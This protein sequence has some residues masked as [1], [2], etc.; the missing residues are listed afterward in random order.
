LQ[1][2]LFYGE[3]GKIGNDNVAFESAPK[4]GT[5]AVLVNAILGDNSEEGPSSSVM[6]VVGIRGAGRDIMANHYELTLFARSK[7]KEVAEERATGSAIAPLKEG[8]LQRVPF[9]VHQTGCFP[10]TL[11]AELG[12]PGRKPA[13]LVERV[14]PFRCEE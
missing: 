9:V 12:L 13:S 7:G 14:I 3:S 2:F 1:A 6:V 4:E 10:M 11:T 5:P 8:V